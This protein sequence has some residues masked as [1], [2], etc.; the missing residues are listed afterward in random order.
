MTAFNTILI[1]YSTVNEEPTSL[2][3]GELAYSEL[4]GKLFVGNESEQAVFVGGVAL[5]SRVG[6]LET[7]VGQVQELVNDNG[8][9]VTDAI[10]LIQSRLDALESFQ[11]A[12]QDQLASI[13]GSVDTV[14]QRIGDAV[15]AVKTD[16]ED[17]IAE[18]ASAVTTAA[19]DA[20]AAELA[21]AVT[22]LEGQITD[23][24]TTA[25]EALTAAQEQQA[26]VN[27]DLSGLIG[28]VAQDLTDFEGETES[29]LQN[30]QTQIDQTS[31][32][33]IAA[34]QS[35]DDELEDLIDSLDTRMGEVKS[36]LN[37]G[38]P[39]FN[40][41]T[42]TGDLVVQGQ[43][44]SIH[45]E[46]T[47]IK[48]PVITLGEGSTV[49]D[50]LGRGVEYEYFDGSAQKVGF[51]GVDTVDGKFKFIPDA[52]ASGN[53][54]TGDAGVIVANVEGTA[55]RL[56]I[57]VDITLNGEVDG[58]VSFDGSANADITVTVVADADAGADSVVRRTATGG[59]KAVDLEVAGAVIG[60]GN[61]ISGFIINGGEF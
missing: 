11:S 6:D 9:S 22:T 25:S 54:F 10:T 34:L 12:A 61:T 39:T 57:P 55:S 56:A 16:L 46:V 17:Q 23:A 47:T 24:G 1:K 33:A 42:V 52:A 59:I 40:S 19:A 29:A 28:Q 50:G 37:D 8:S 35:K 43:T 32:V 3:K 21:A 18:S 5:V 58:V 15:A 51:F 48:D 27:S 13:Q 49:V 41:V 44:V 45:S 53:A 14:D 38:S 20:A 60:T 7:L 31:N 4:S 36:L 2:L 30:L 26:L